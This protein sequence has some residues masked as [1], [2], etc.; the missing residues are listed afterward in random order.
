MQIEERDNLSPRNEFLTIEQ[1]GNYLQKPQST[2]NAYIR[3][4]RLKAYR[5]IGKRT[6]YVHYA[7]LQRLLE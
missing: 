1:A 4:G 2:I 6:I 7:D 5:I 3:S